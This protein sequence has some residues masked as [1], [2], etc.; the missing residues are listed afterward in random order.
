MATH[1][2]IR[3]HLGWRYLRAY[4]QILFSTWRLYLWV[5]HP[6]WRI[7]LLLQWALAFPFFHNDASLTCFIFYVL[8]YHSLPS[9]CL[10]LD[11]I[12]RKQA[13]LGFVIQNH[14]FLSRGPWSRVTC[15]LISPKAAISYRQGGGISH[16]AQSFYFLNNHIFLFSNPRLSIYVIFSHFS[17]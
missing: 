4:S 17:P 10:P 7:S 11:K 9:P 3:W 5:T 1:P 2:S 6:T 13:S 8:K 15:H 16:L 14:T 12:F